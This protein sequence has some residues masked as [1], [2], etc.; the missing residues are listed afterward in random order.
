MSTA[1]VRINPTDSQGGCHEILEY[2]GQSGSRPF[3][4]PGNAAVLGFPVGMG[5]TACAEHE[6]RFELP[7]AEEGYGDPYRMGMILPV[8]DGKPLPANLPQTICHRR[9]TNGDIAN[10]TCVNG[11]FVTQI[12][13]ERRTMPETFSFG[14]QTE[15]G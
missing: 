5:Q 14:R 6:I 4:G 7:G 11:T 15:R 9:D 13:E 8:L 10:G 2:L 12:P 3:E 1:L